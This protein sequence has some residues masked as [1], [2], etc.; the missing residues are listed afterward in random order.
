MK[1]LS[2]GALNT[3]EYWDFLFGFSSIAAFQSSFP[4]F[5]SY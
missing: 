3:A 2:S 1:G 4:S 5:K